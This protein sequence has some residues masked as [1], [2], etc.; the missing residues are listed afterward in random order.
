AIVRSIGGAPVRASA[1]VLR[2]HGRDRSLFTST[3]ALGQSVV[4]L[5]GMMEV[6]MHSKAW[7]W[8]VGASVVALACGDDGAAPEAHL[9]DAA[10]SDAA[11]GT[12]ASDVGTDDEDGRADTEATDD[13]ADGGADVGTDDDAAVHESDSTEPTP[14]DDDPAVDGGLP[15]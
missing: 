8:A 5:L 13:D 14:T 2:A 11:E 1:R 12:V 3:A 7:W 9:G 15:D 10:A 4:D 6:S